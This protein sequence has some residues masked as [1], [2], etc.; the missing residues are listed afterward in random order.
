[1]YSF[2]IIF[3]LCRTKRSVKA[4]GS[5]NLFIAGFSVPNLV[6]VTCDFMKNISKCLNEGIGELTWLK[7]SWMTFLTCLIRD[8]ILDI[9]RILIEP[10]HSYGTGPPEYAS[11]VPTLK[12]NLFVR[13][14]PCTSS[15]P[16]VKGR[17]LIPGINGV[18][19][20]IMLGQGE[21]S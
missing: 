20:Q 13:D 7:D 14:G 1:M 2:N 4:G 6:P 5:S 16:N 21:L 8:L 12:A 15:V 17:C 9:P 19:G 3:I 11:S 10:L 18:L